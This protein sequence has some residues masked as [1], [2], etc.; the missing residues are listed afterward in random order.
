[1]PCPARQPR[2]KGRFRNA[3]RLERDV[4]STPEVEP[5]TD[6]RVA[7]AARI[8]THARCRLG[9]RVIDLRVVVR[10]QGLV[11]RGHAHTYYAKQLAQHAVMEATHLLILANEIDVS[12]AEIE[13]RGGVQ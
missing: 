5:S 8:E 11:L 6:P 3:K 7:E 13:K 2:S 12:R 9:S 4:V 10:E 1:M